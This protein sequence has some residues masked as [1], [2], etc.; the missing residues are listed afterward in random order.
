MRDGGFLLLL[1]VLVNEL[2]QRID[3]K[4]IR[5]AQSSDTDP[6][7]GSPFALP[8][9]HLRKRL[10]HQEHEGASLAVAMLTPTQGRRADMGEQTLRRT[11]MHIDTRLQV[12]SKE[13][14]RRGKDLYS[15]AK[16]MTS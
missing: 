3:A 15:Q 2:S 5:R 13:M 11:S 8:Q 1:F 9:Y 16:V 12:L 4:H 14:Q 10:F 7:H 6:D